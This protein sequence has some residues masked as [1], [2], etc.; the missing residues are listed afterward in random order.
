LNP[1]DKLRVPA[2]WPRNS[3]QKSG[4]DGGHEPAAAARGAIALAQ[5]FGEID[6]TQI[7]RFQQR[8]GIEATGSYGPAT[9]MVLCR[10][11]GIVP[12]CPD[13]WGSNE[14]KSRAQFA[15]AMYGEAK[16]DSAR[17][18]EFRHVARKAEGKAA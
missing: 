8:E 6:P 16:R 5:H 1:G 12:P 4:A 10:R 2:D 14:R 15:R 13:V 9:A 17:R 18:D 7:L 3:Q 11:Y